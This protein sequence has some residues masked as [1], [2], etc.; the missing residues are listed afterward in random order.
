MRGFTLAKALH[1]AAVASNHAR[2]NTALTTADTD[3]PQNMKDWR[4]DV[5]DANL[6]AA[7]SAGA[8]WAWS[9]AASFADKPPV[10]SRETE[11]VANEQ[12]PYY[13]CSSFGQVAATVNLGSPSESLGGVNGLVAR[14]QAYASALVILEDRIPFPVAGGASRDIPDL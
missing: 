5:G 13:S 4:S 14:Y 1:D 8:Y 3:V 7:D 10:L 9:G 12:K 6:D 11:P 2:N